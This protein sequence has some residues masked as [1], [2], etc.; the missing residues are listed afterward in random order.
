MGQ[1][2]VDRGRD[3]QGLRGQTDREPVGARR[4][5][6]EVRV[7]GLDVQDGARGIDPAQGVTQ[8]TGDHDA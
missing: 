8:S 6:L 1:G 7:E 5:R 2:A 4:Q 3:P